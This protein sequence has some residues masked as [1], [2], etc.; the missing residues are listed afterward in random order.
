VEVSGLP[1]YYGNLDYTIKSLPA[2]SGNSP[3]EVVVTVGG[4]VAM[5]PGGII[6]KSPLTQPIA[7]VA[8]DGRL[9]TPGSGEI[10]L[11]RLPAKVSILY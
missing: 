8:G 2:P 10:R 4:T 1:T 7:S 3:R 11:D 9:V 5:P 6:L